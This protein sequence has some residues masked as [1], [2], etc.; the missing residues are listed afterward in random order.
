MDR[1]VACI[2]SVVTN[3][4]SVA[5]L[6]VQIQTVKSSRQR[7]SANHGNVRSIQSDSM[8]CKYNLLYASLCIN[9]INVL[10]NRRSRTGKCVSITYLLAE[11]ESSQMGINFQGT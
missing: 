11:S 6:S 4:V 8:I 10:E 9:G 1:I 3:L 7:L 5:F 2:P